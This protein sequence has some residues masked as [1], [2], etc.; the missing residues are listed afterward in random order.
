MN[1]QNTTPDFPAELDQGDIS[2]IEAA[3]SGVITTR[4]QSRR[5]ALQVLSKTG[6]E[7]AEQFREPAR[8]ESVI[9]LIEIFKAA[10][11]AMDAE[12]TWIE[13]AQARLVVVVDDAIRAFSPEDSEQQEAS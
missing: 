9:E 6:D 5:L 10:L 12:R 13:A 8:I 7:L 2:R 3:A 11:D 1:T 4:N